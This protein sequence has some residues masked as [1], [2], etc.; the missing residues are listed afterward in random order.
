[1]DIIRLAFNMTTAV[2]EFVKK[3]RSFYYWVILLDYR[4]PRCNGSLVMVAEGRCKCN[5]C[6]NELD[7]TAR[8]LTRPSESH[9]KECAGDFNGSS[10][11]CTWSHF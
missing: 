6:Q 3:V 7:P 8:R 2:Q 1:M 5:H 11:T 4:C 9:V 10:I